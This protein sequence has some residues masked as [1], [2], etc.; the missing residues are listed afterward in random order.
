[1]HRTEAGQVLVEQ[2][3]HPNRQVREYLFALLDELSRPE[4]AI[5]R[6]AD[7]EHR[8]TPCFPCG[9]GVL[10][11]NITRAQLDEDGL[12]PV[13]PPERV[14]CR[15]EIAALE[16]A[17]DREAIRRLRRLFPAWFR[18]DPL[19]EDQVKTLK[20][21]LHREVVVRKRPATAASVPQGQPVL[22]GA[23]ALDVL[24][25]D[26]EQAARALGR[27]HHVL[28]GIAGSG[29]TVLLRARARLLAA[30]DP[31]RRILVL[32]FNK[33]LAAAL[34]AQ[35]ASA[36]DRPT[37]EVR[38]FHSWAA[39]LT[40]LRKGDEESFDAY[41]GRLV[42]ALRAGIAQMPET[43]KYDAILVDEGHD[44]AA[45]WLRCVTGLLRGGPEGDLLIVLDGAQRLYGRGSKFTWKAV[46]I[47]AQGRSRRLQRFLNERLHGL[48]DRPGRGRKP[49]FSSRGGDARGED[50]L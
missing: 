50:R 19:T 23:V 43:E 5:L 31:A 12:T 41:E 35:I 10:L 40:G 25:A 26:Q 24:D 9:Y 22:P 17:G 21:A 2:H 15:D 27:G 30:R 34:G 28:F 48:R 45:D 1:L 16:G 33:A 18:S 11:T 4:F 3:A 39:R 7:G 32:C 20:G 44:F 29:K 49:V 42:A 8:G 36:P 37:I 13:F 6:Q 46:G 47:Q 38:G 14:F